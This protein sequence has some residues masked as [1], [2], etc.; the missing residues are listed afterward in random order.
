MRQCVIPIV[1]KN[2]HFTRRVWLALGLAPVLPAFARARRD[3]SFRHD[4]ILGT[5]LDLTVQ[6]ATAEEAE[7][8]ETAVLGEVERLRKILDVRDAASDIRV[9]R[10]SA[11]LHQVLDA[12]RHWGERTGGVIRAEW[13]GSPNLEGLG[14]AYIVDRAAGAGRAAAPGARGLVLDIGGDIRVFGQAEL[15]IADPLRPHDNAE[16]MTMVRIA[17]QALTSSGTY[18][19]G[20]H[21]VDGRTGLVA[22]G[23]LAASV[24]ASDCLTSNALSMALCVLSPDEGL[25]LLEETGGAE[26]LVVTR[27]GGVLRSSGFRRYEQTLRP[28]AYAGWTNGSQVS[29]SLTLVDPAPAGGGG[30]GFGGR[31][32]FGGKG[33]GFGR[34]KRPYVAVWAEDASG[35]VVKNIT[36]WASKPRWLP[37]LHTWWSKNGASARQASQMARATRAAGQYSLAWNGM[38]DSGEPAPAGVYK[39]WIET[40]R[41][42]GTHYQDSVTID[43]SGKPASATGKGTPEFEDVKVSFGPVTGVV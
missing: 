28:A 43:C 29:I 15:G 42:H 4:Y 27:S 3:Y 32:G 12:Y 33:G 2:T 37:E 8:A 31:G 30:G 5:S 17:D 7:S 24:T 18:A 25:R 16:P 9:G 10:R 20:P 11:D 38:T 40:N 26:G 22:K 19:R 39:I 21:I 6:G 1:T 13:N 35:K 23:A 41:E 34:M 36:L 14:K